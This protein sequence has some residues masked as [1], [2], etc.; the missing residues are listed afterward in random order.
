MVGIS[1]VARAHATSSRVAPVFRIRLP[2][3]A[4]IFVK[5]ICDIICLVRHGQPQA[6]EDLREVVLTL[7]SGLFFCAIRRHPSVPMFDNL[8]QGKYNQT[9]LKAQIG[10]TH[11]GQ[12]CLST[13]LHGGLPCDT[14]VWRS[15]A[16]RHPLLTGEWWFGDGIYIAEHGILAKK[17]KPTD[18]N[19]TT[20]ELLYNARI[21]HYRARAEHIIAHV[22]THG[23][24]KTACRLERPQVEGIWKLL[25]HATA[26]RIRQAGPLYQGYGPAY[27]F[28]AGTAS[29]AYQK[30]VVDN[31]LYK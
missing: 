27:H 31:E 10:V 24:F 20:F 17:K 7:C 21:D 8:N 11:L 19:L 2:I 6:L 5:I 26:L 12:I 13:G 22:K 15:T 18:R 25:V 23:F 3:H 1:L 30:H 9:I 29:R 4:P 28:E 16:D 14:E